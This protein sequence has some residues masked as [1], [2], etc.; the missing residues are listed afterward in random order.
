MADMYTL[1]REGAGGGGRESSYV[2]KLPIISPPP[3]NNSSHLK[4]LAKSQENMTKR[5]LNKYKPRGL[6]SEFYGT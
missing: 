1:D 5:P 3:E 6:L 4:F 2:R